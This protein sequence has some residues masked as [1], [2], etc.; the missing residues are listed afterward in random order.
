MSDL[1]RELNGLVKHW[2]E[3]GLEK[4]KTSELVADKEEERLLV[5]QA[6]AYILCATKL[7]AI[8]AHHGL[9]PSE[10]PLRDHK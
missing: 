6:S 7:K 3:A 2:A 8:L 10:V 1:Q 4:I 5:H 9:A